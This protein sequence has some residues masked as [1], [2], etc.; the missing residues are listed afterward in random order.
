MAEF[1]KEAS[2]ANYKILKAQE[3]TSQAKKESAK[4]KVQCSGLEKKDLARNVEHESLAKQNE[5][6]DKANKSIIDQFYNTKGEFIGLQS[7]VSHL[8]GEIVSANDQL[9]QK[10]EQLKCQ[11]IR[12]AG[13]EKEKKDLE[14]YLLQQKD[15]NESLEDVIAALRERVGV[16]DSQASAKS[17]ELARLEEEKST[18]KIDLEAASK[19]NVGLMMKLQLSQG[20][21][22][23]VFQVN[24]EQKRVVSSLRVE[25]EGLE[26][27]V[28]VLDSL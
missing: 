26:Q 25:Q 24:K 14:D 19:D 5:R 18:V 11:K 9:A 22:T 10:D 1:E 4:I 20:E 23:R 3:E 28:A 17:A 6:L 16:R 21:V 15:V 8:E 12:V 27:R 13:I 2:D 7:K